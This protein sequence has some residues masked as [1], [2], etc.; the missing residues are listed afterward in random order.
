MD[1]ET[2]LVWNVRGLHAGTHR[3]AL[4]NLVVAK[5]LS[6]VCIQETKLDVISDFDQL[7]RHGFEY[8][9][10]LAVHTRGGIL[11]AWRGSVWAVSSSSTQL[12]SVLIRLHR[13][14]GIPEWWLYG[15]VVDDD[16]VS[17]LA[18]LHDLCQVRTGPWMI[19][20]DFNRIYH[21]EDK[22]NDRLN[23]HRMG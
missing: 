4:H 22:N 23:R 21:A 8:V 11:V 20:G 2:F 3:N 14:D 10:L 5:G 9:Y 12:F 15:P 17:F 1:P 13:A 19:N 18:E 7:L 6:L 16:K